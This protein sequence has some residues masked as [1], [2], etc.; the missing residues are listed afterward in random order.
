M[1]DI[2]VKDEKVFLSN[3][4]TT[5]QYEIKKIQEIYLKW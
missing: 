5:N 2:K 1:I 4:L 3:G